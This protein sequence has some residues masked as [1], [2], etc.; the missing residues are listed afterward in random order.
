MNIRALLANRS[1][2][3]VVAVAA[4]V[5]IWLVVS[6]SL[7]AFLADSAPRAA[8]WLDPQQPEALVNLADQALNTDATPE[9][10]AGNAGQ[11]SAQPA[12]DSSQ[13]TD[14]TRKNIDHAFSKF[15]KFGRNQSM[16][17]P[18][19][20]NNEAVVRARA[21][22]A[23]TSDPLNARAL[24]ILGELAEADNDDAGA[25][26]FMQA[27]ARLSRHESA[28]V[29]WLLRNNAE[30]GNYQ[31]AIYF[32]DVLLRT[33]PQSDR[34]VIPVL[35]QI[36]EDRDG[37]ALLK[38]ALARDPPW[39]GQFIS[40]LPYNV[41]DART[42]LDLLLT[43]RTNPVPPKP[44]EIGPY[45]Y[46]LIAHNFYSLAYYTWLQFL[47]PEELR[48]AGL[49]FNGNFEGELSGLPF[50]WKIT[51]GT[52]VTVDVVPRTDK[53][54]GHALLVDFQYGRVDYHSVTE[55]VMLAP[56][57]YQFNGE[58]K[59]SLV[60]PRGM[61]WRVVCANGTV[62]NGGESPTIIGLTPNWQNVSFTFTVPAKDCPAQYV[63]LDLDARMTSEHLI[64]G[65]VLFDELQ[66][67]R[68][69]SPSTS[70]G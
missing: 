60:G 61:K 27:A 46:F 70:G 40:Q 57:A 50:D 54:G 47:P 14:D 9:V 25:A 23:L 63:R 52:G 10:G 55:L 56:G 24:R 17:R 45:I 7:S 19:A 21:T 20:P 2:T 48:H 16:N 43:L 51:P 15:E 53:N 44:D 12:A 42:P 5:L 62:T 67:S 41:T 49:L 66:I 13:Y 38:A 59:G 28:A 35:G 1:R 68:V 32:A 39:R 30:A 6:R 37:A 65:S 33:S 64:S 4:L 29:Y 18:I 22:T 31:A 34:F 3:I 8:L 11:T 69:A 36:S 58:Y 26:K